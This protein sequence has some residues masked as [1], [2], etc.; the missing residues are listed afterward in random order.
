MSTV[1]NFCSSHGKQRLS[2]SHPPADALFMAKTVIPY[3]FNRLY[4][5]VES[6]QNSGIA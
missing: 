6:Q 3:L 1:N 4:K 5:E 2:L